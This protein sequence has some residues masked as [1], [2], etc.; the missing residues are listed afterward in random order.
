MERDTWTTRE[1][2]RAHVRPY[3]PNPLWGWW[4]GVV[5]VT[6][7]GCAMPCIVCRPTYNQAQK[8][9]LQTPQDRGKRNRQLCKRLKHRKVPQD[10]THRSGCK[11]L[12]GHRIQTSQSQHELSITLEKP[13][14]HTRLPHQLPLLSFSFSSSSSS[15]S[16]SLSSSSSSYP[17]RLDSPIGDTTS[18]ITAGPAAQGQQVFNRRT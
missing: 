14:S 15:S 17:R 8:T 11:P 18:D 16:S 10:A 2:I 3:L 7:N 6:L 1:M 4:R 9:N 12:H 13:K 5:N